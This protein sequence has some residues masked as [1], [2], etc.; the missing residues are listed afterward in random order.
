MMFQHY[1]Y[2]L[3]IDFYQIAITEMM[4]TSTLTKNLLKNLEDIKELQR[5]YNVVKQAYSL[6]WKNVCEPAFDAVLKAKKAH[7]KVTHKFQGDYDPWW[8]YT[9]SEHGIS[10]DWVDKPKNPINLKIGTEYYIASK[11]SEQLGGR[12]WKFKTVLMRA[13]YSKVYEVEGSTGDL[14]Q[15]K[16]LD[17]IY[18]FQYGRYTWEVITSDDNF[19]SMEL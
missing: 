6:Y 9:A 16:V 10:F 12:L 11:R 15:V 1:Q 7:V 8:L 13:I 17:R 18:W 19:K 3:Q 4:A 5:R 14:L 2:W